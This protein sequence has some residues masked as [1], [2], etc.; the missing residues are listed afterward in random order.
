VVDGSTVF[1]SDANTGENPGFVNVKAATVV[2][3]YFEHGVP[4]VKELQ[5]RQGLVVRENR[6]DFKEI[7]L[8][9]VSL[10]HSLF[11]L[12]TTDTI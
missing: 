5:E 10:R 11:P 6:V 1:V 12:R 9:A 8:R 4:P 7:S 3:K 2:E